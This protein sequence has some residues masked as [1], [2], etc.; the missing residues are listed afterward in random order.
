LI[1]NQSD[2]IELKRKQLDLNILETE[3]IKKF[4]EGNRK[5]LEMSKIIQ[6]IK[7]KRNANLEFRISQSHDEFIEI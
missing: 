3:K 7:N 4:E 5:S 6:K 1:K 2:N